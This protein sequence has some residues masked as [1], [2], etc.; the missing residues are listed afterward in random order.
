MGHPYLE[1]GRER[2]EEGVDVRS[3]GMGGFGEHC[4]AVFMGICLNCF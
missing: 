1:G 3:R 2:G 4:V